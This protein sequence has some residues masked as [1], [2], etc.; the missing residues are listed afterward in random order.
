MD[1]NILLQKEV[2][3]NLKA[4]KKA[5]GIEEKGK[6]ESSKVVLSEDEHMPKLIITPENKLQDTADEIQKI[7]TQFTPQKD[8]NSAVDVDKTL[9]EQ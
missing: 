3:K 1:I 5:E 7:S 9:D 4:N 8:E 6:E 2:E